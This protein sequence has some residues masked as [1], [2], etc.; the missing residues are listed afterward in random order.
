MA[1]G[2]EP[3]PNEWSDVPLS[4]YFEDTSLI[5]AGT[6]RTYIRCN[7]KQIC[8][9]IYGAIDHTYNAGTWFTVKSKYL[10]KGI[11]AT[12]VVTNGLQDGGAFLL[13][14]DTRNGV[15]TNN[16]SGTPIVNVNYLMA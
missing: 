9:C 10:P 2:Y 6:N 11:Y 4:D 16:I 7:G 1:E 8:G 14:S 15:L 13:N 12:Q 5:N 3:R